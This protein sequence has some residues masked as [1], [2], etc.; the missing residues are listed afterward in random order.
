MIFKLGETYCADLEQLL[1][2][3]QKFTHLRYLDV[4]YYLILITNLLQKLIKC[5]VFGYKQNSVFM[6]LFVTVK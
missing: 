1:C 2:T 6:I 4:K 5:S 3:L